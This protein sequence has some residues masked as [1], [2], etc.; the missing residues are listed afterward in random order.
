MNSTD[1][2]AYTNPAF[3]AANINEF[4]KG[5]HEKKSSCFFPIIY[6]VTPI[7]LSKKINKYLENTNKKTE[8]LNLLYRH[9]EVTLELSKMISKTKQYSDRAIMFGNQLGI[10]EIDSKG[11][12]SSKRNIP[13]KKISE[14]NLNYL[15]Y[16]NRLGYWLGSLDESEIFYNL[17]VLL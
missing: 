8:F 14:Q 17:G 15:K 2:Y 11:Y 12:V 9:P 5:Y 10:F 3:L 6:L 16:A 4:L 7:V 1:I 13:Q